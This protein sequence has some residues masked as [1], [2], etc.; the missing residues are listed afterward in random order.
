MRAK[1]VWI[2]AAVVFVLSFIIG[3]SGI[4]NG[5]IAAPLRRAVLAEQATPA[6]QASPDQ[7]IQVAFQRALQDESNQVLGTMI[8]E[9][10]V[11]DIFYSND[12]TT[13]ILWIAL[14]DPQS[15]EVIGTEPG[16]AIAR[17]S[18]R[19]R[20][21][22]PASWAIT[23]QSS[24]EFEEQIKTLPG[25]LLTQ[26]LKTSLSEIS[27]NS[28][29]S[30]KDIPVLTGYKLPWAAGLAKRLTGS[31]GH[32]LLYKSCNEANC[33]FAY[34]FGDGTMYP[35]LAAKG[36][37]VAAYRD[38][39]AN[40]DHNCTNYITL[41]DDSTSP[42][43][44]QLY[45][46]LANGTISSRL[47]TIGAQVNQGEFIANADN[48]GASTGHHLHFHVFAEST[49]SN[50]FWGPS[51]NIAFDDVKINSG[52]PRT[53]YEAMNWPGYG[54]E[55]QP[56][57]DGVRGTADDD[58]FVSGN[59]P[60]HIPSG[61]VDL[62][63]NRQVITGQTLRI[64]GAAQD[65]VQVT[66]IQIQ[67][68]YDGSWETIDNI[69]SPANGP[70]AKDVDLCAAKVPD[71]PF[72]LA[73]QIFNREGS[74]APNLPVKQLIK[75]FNC[76][77]ANQPPQETIL[78]SP[79]SNRIMVNPFA[80]TVS[81]K[82]SDGGA[83]SRVDF[84][85]HGADWNKPWIKLGAD[86]NGSD[87]WSY[88]LAPTAYG[89]IPG[90]AL[91]VQAVGKNGSARGIA[92]WDLQPDSSSPV[93]QLN[94]LPGR[95]NSTVF[96]L[97]WS[98]KDDP[99]D[100]LRFDLQ[101][102]EN[103]GDWKDWSAASG[104][105]AGN[106]RSV[107]FTGK[108]GM[109]YKFRIRAV[110]QAGNTEDWP[111]QPEASTSVG[112]TCS[113]D[114]EVL[115]QSISNATQIPRGGYS[116]LFNF[117]NRTSIVSNGTGGA[118]DVDWLSF[119]ANAGEDLWFRFI[120]EGG[121]VAFKVNLYQNSRTLLKTWQSA[122]YEKAID[123]SWKAPTTGTYYLEIKPLYANMFGTDMHYQVWFD[124]VSRQYFPIVSK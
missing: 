41:R 1:K 111:A 2:A 14:I 7:A 31:V 113:A 54:S 12:Q 51:V 81:A 68:N 47:R 17:R 121:G 21:T 37:T 4:L 25:E 5:T 99:G 112:A 18:A 82:D 108:P 119:K 118:N 73:V 90:S 59:V 78:L 92:R 76:N 16:L 102:Q 60:P 72:A 88:T 101:F 8:Y 32:F 33:R 45:Y 87:G 75:N 67:V 53:C 44:Y 96:Q 95:I 63:A 52:Q 74:P 23:L 104:P 13:A 28:A 80:I 9:T 35:V 36:G 10:S 79:S 50:F 106:Q 40:G 120:P 20:S 42:V 49:F 26:E 27:G 109:N 98:A 15:K 86:T 57:P 24:P 56:G 3:I 117:C 69:A 65:D 58:R 48:T 124:H 55:C 115:G 123:T 11:Q 43:T 114:N 61:S 83:V 107:W 70:Y 22:D 66:N 30:R 105:I 84:Y 89:S 116:P 39:C 103:G 94:A 29:Q 19:S 100:I 6:L 91:Y 71:G 97:N 122:D 64:Q 62:P 110:D 34:D 77:G 38:T 85:W 93:S 46:H